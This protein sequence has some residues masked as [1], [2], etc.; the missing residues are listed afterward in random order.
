MAEAILGGKFTAMKAFLKKPRK[1][2]NNPKYQLKEFEKEEQTNLKS[3]E[4]R[5][6]TSG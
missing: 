1:I 4:K 3:E 5:L 6:K 2:S